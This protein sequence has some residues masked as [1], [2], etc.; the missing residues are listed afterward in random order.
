[1]IF[2]GMGILAARRVGYILG[3]KRTAMM[4]DTSG[5]LDIKR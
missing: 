5:P 1:M 2:S 3:D 4:S